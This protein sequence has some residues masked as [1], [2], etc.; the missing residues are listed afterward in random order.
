MKERATSYVKGFIL[1]CLVIG[2]GY[3]GYHRYKLSTQKPQKLIAA[4]KKASRR[5]IQD[6][7]KKKKGKDKLKRKRVRQEYF[8]RMLRDPATN[9]IP[10][11]I[12]AHEMNHARKMP[13]LHQF[14][15]RMQAKNG[16][17]P[18]G[19]QWHFAGPPD[20]GGR[21]RALGIDQRNSNVIIAGGV[22]GGIW[23]STNGGGSWKLKTGNIDNYSVTT[24]DQDPTHP[25]TWYYAGGEYLGNSASS[26]FDNHAIAAYFGTGIFKSTDNGDTWHRI[27]STKDTD[28]QFDSQFGFVSRLRIS[29]KTGTIFIASNGIG[30]FRSDDGKNFNH[31][32]LGGGSRGIAGRHAFVDVAVASDGTVAAA[33][34]TAGAGQSGGKSGIFISHDDGKK[35]HWIEVTPTSFPSNYRRSVLAFAPSDP[36]ILYVFTLKGPSN[37]SNQG[38]SFYKLDL[39]GNPRGAIDRAGNLPHFGGPVGNINT[40][41]GYNMIVQVKPDDP[42]F[43]VVGATDLF[44]SFDGFATGPTSN[45]GA[46]KDKYWIGGYAKAND[47][48][49]YPNH[50]CDQHIMMFDP[51]DPDRM[52]SGNDGGVQVTRDVTARSVTWKSL[53]SDYYVTQFYDASLPPAAGSTYLMGG[54]QDNGTPFFMFTQN[55]GNAS[56]DITSGDGGYS[57]FTN[58]Y[59]Y[60][61][62]AKEGNQNSIV[63]RWKSDFSGSFN[64]VQPAQAKTALFIDPY[65]VDPNDEGIMYYAGESELYR[66]RKVDKITNLQSSGTTKGWELMHNAMLPGYIISA[67][68]V[69]TMPANILY[70]A[71]STTAQRPPVIKKLINASTSTSEPKDVSI[72]NAP[73]GAYLHDLAVNPANGNDVLAVMTNY[74]IVGLYHTLDGGETWT[75]VEGNLKGSNKPKSA[76]AGPS[77]RTATIVPAESG[78]IYLV[79]T[80]TGVYSTRTFDGDK[81]EWKHESPAGNDGKLHIG[82][83]VVEDITSRFSDGDVAVGTH[84]RG[85]FVGRFQGSTVSKNVPRITIHPQKGRGGNP[86][87]KQPGEAVQITATNFNFA[88][89]DSVYFNGI[90]AIIKTSSF[91]VE[92]ITVFVPRVPIPAQ[93]DLNEE[94]NY[95]VNVTVKRNG[96]GLSPT[97]TFTILSPEKNELSQNYPNPFNNNTNIPIAVRRKSHVTLT[98]YNVVGRQV[99]QPLKDKTFAPGSHNIPIDFSGHASGVYIYRIIITPIDQG[100]TFTA[101]RK[102][103]LIR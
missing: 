86:M 27:P 4:A 38:V 97:T 44:R 95:T 12:H 18:K 84:G 25:D 48:S 68:S 35:G 89:N 32:V 60:A 19:F 41:G 54:T 30:I 17:A 36:N 3:W 59:I 73:N 99:D 71:G 81:T 14:R 58:N 21:T 74:D 61:S 34:S 70:Y 15:L 92:T 22:S 64:Y 87:R 55:M 83:S 5:L 39:S 62:L 94:G 78:P 26:R 24:L 66:N 16:S 11:N 76:D 77:L 6:V 28:T 93:A 2:V 103:T 88:K 51:H 101:A 96:N 37:T 46:Q 9:S 47:V 29:P 82:Y 56:A 31:F 102:F 53:N 57:F 50:H 52:W 10:P 1:L 65:A 98:I 8:F 90:P 80:S 72:P 100:N 23:K 69:T 42:N 33:L 40:Q 45:S 20:V 49:Q 43:V 67:V 7:K 63:I 13:T 79:G 91:P 85:M 75:A